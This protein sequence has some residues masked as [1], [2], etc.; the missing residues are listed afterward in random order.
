[1][2]IKI[3]KHTGKESWYGK[4]RTISSAEAKSLKRRE[5]SDERP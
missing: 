1:M 4:M 3:N 2:I 5:S